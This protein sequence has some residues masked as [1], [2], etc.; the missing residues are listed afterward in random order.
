MARHFCDRSHHVIVCGRTEST[1]RQAAADLPG[2]RPI[3]ADVGDAH[4]RQALFDEITRLADVIE[5]ILR[6]AEGRIRP[7]GELVRD[8][9]DSRGSRRLRRRRGR[10]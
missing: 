3:R 4:D 7:G 2:V 8:P 6:D 1:L 10:L 5:V 9:H